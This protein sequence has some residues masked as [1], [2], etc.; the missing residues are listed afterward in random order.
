MDYVVRWIVFVAA[1]P[2]LLAGCQTERTVSLKEAKK[3][4]A[5]FT[6]TTYV[7]P[8]RTISDITAVL[9]QYKVA[10]PEAAAAA[11]AKAAI[12]PPSNLD[13]WDLVQFYIDRGLAARRIGR[14]S[15]ELSDLTFA[16]K[17]SRG[18]KGAVRREALW[19]LAGA[20]GRAGNRKNTNEHRKEALQYITLSGRRVGYTSI[21]AMTLGAAG[22]LEEA[23]Q[24]V[25]QAETLLSQMA[26]T[27]AWQNN[28][29]NYIYRVLWAKGMLAYQKGLL[30]ESERLYRESL[31]VAL[32]ETQ[33]TVR[34]I[35]NRMSVRGKLAQALAVQGK[36]FE[37]EFLLRKSLT[38]A[39]TRYGKYSQF[40]AQYLKGLS[41]VIVEQGRFAEGE[42]LVRAT[43][44]IYRK[45]GAPSDANILNFTRGTLAT[46]LA[47]QERWQESYREYSD[48][49]N[50]TKDDPK[51][52]DRLLKSNL[53]WFITLL[54]TGKTSDVLNTIEDL[55]RKRL[56]LFTA[57]KKL[58]A[59]LNGIHAMALADAGRHKESLAAFRKAVPVLLD[60]AAR[61]DTAESAASTGT[62]INDMILDRY[63]RFLGDIENSATGSQ[64][65]LNIPE[66]AFR[67]ADVIRSR[68]VQSALSSSA[69]RSAAGTGELADYARREQDAAKQIQAI[70]GLLTSALSAP[71]DQQDPAA[72]ESLGKRL[73]DLKLA[74]TALLKEIDA[75]FPDYAE[76]INPKPLS[77]KDA[78]THMRA[79][80][81]MLA[82]YVGDKKTYVWAVPKSG[83]VK[84]AA[85]NLGRDP[86]GAR[87]SFLRKALDPGAVATLGDI[88]AFDIAGAHDLYAKLLKPV[89]A[90]WKGAK[91]LLVV[92]DG[93]LGQLP[94]SL[95]P[96][97]PAKL[98]RDDRLLF[99]GYRAIPWLARTHGVT[100]L[101]SVASLKSLRG[102]RT[103]QGPRRP[104]LGI[105]DPFFN[106][107]QQSAARK[108]AAATQLASRGVS[109]RS[110]PK[111]R[112]A[113]S[114]E[115][116]R[117]PRLPDT[118]TEIQSIGTVL[119]ADPKRDIYL[120][121]RADEETVKS[122]DMMPYRV[123][124][125]ATH[126][127]I[128]GDL[129][130]LNQPALALS[131]PKVTGGKGDGLLTMEEILGLRLNADW[132]VLSACNTAAADGKGAEAI[133]GLGRA[134][135]YAG[136]RALLVSNWPVHSG[137]TAH[138]MTDLFKRQ[139]SSR[140]LNRAEAL[141]QTRLHLI[142]K[143]AVK[144]DDKLAF[145]Y[146]HP[147]FWA[148]FTLVGDGG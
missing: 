114:A 17:L 104:F 35:E 119:M 14:F 30:K 77:L 27:R 26:G 5:K 105:G 42:K 109:L 137:A 43:I 99:A 85:V 136:A 68:S 54:K 132:A 79:G 64:A 91:S 44:D 108:Q 37:A 16:E 10:D 144:L 25:K 20:D 46:V 38:D 67:V 75:K 3:I 1:L 53:T 89:E 134:F 62:W 113:D 58:T 31:R 8:P 29:G 100:V 49:W 12:K 92:A 128:P 41:R 112:S 93:A 147:I 125:F 90:G 69:A 13:K 34:N 148:P 15:Q 55:N 111:T 143:G 95:L 124:S 57:S 60:R 39:L 82:F 138:L 110:A 59:Q 133:S 74:R 73:E 61:S 96:T 116:E 97:G 88:P 141:R 123:I 135:F 122:M 126:G 4:T 87:V 70:S 117:L 131:S 130:G 23:D 28:S 18:M 102:T 94:F 80:E 63:L 36:L 51:L 32:T 40:P 118:R 22:R 81:A 140:G 107:R 121:R 146:A 115:I 24:T 7:P 48:I 76:L 52:Q 2:L 145:S 11:Q 72:N 86:L 19:E 139:A 6:G 45:I 21:L 101:P 103:A 98:K 84:F 65:G 71:P 127:L 9:D 83:A 56:R 50:N 66:E 47:R 78:R 142:D 129:N 120:G 106:K 33:E